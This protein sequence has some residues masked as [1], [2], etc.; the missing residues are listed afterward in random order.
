[1]RI[2]D[3]AAGAGVSTRVLRYYEQQ[4]LL[5]STRTPAGHRQYD[6]SAVERVRLIQLFYGA[7]LSSKAIREV[8]PSV[9]AGEVAPGVVE[10]LTAER[11]RVE[12]RISDLH[13]VRD[14][15][16]EVIDAAV[17]PHHDC[18]ATSAP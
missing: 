7:G 2:G 5:V 16:D 6:E 3:V 12:Q 17:N 9:D 11:R 1:M 8:L 13:G 18:A 10:L 14:R 4:R 15:L